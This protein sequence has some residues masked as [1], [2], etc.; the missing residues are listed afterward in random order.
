MDLD[1]TLPGDYGRDYEG[2]ILNHRGGC[3][4]IHASTLDELLDKIMRG[5]E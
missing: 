1:V 5:E 4:E 3:V 2:R